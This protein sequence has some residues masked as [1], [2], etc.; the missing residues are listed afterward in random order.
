MLARNSRWMLVALAL[1]I[2]FAT[3]IAFKFLEAERAVEAEAAAQ[4]AAEQVQ[5]SAEA[6]L[7][8][9]AVAP[10]A[11]AVESGAQRV[12]V[13]GRTLTIHVVDP[14]GTPAV[15]AK[16]ALFRAEELLQ[17]AATDAQGSARFNA[18]EGMAEYALFAPGWALTRG[19]IDL[20]AGERTLTL[21]EGEVI[22]GS[23]LVDGAFPDPPIELDF[24]AADRSNGL[25]ALPKSVG[26]AL[27]AARGDVDG[28]IARTQANGA[29]E[30]RGLPPASAGTI[31][32]KGPY[33][34]EDEA[35][36]RR[37]NFVAVPAPRR[38]LLLRLTAGFELR[39]RVVDAAG[40]PVAGAPVTLYT[41]SS[42]P[43]VKNSGRM[44]QT[45]DSEGR[46]TISMSLTENTTISIDVDVA[47]VG[48]AGVR[49]YPAVLPA[50]PRGVID[51]GDLATDA[52]HQLSVRVRD[53]TEKAVEG[54]IVGPLPWHLQ[55]TGRTDAAGLIQLRL[56]ANDREI[57]A[58]AIGF[59]AAR[60]PVPTNASEL[61]VTLTKAT[62]LEFEIVPASEVKRELSVVLVGPATMFIG[63]DD[64]GPGTP[65]GGGRYSMDWGGDTTKC[66]VN[67]DKD[68]HWRIMGLVTNESMH[69]A[70]RGADGPDLWAGEIAPLT[71][72]EHRVVEMRLDAE[73]K[74]LRVRVLG[75][76]GK[77]QP[78]A[79]VFV[80][81]GHNGVQRHGLAVDE[82]GEVELQSLF[83]DRCTLEARA[84][85]FPA[86]MVVLHGVPAGTFDI[87]LDAPR[88][89][90]VDLVTPTGVLYE[91]KAR[92]RVQYGTMVVESSTPISPGRYRLDNLP[93]TEILIEAQ[94]P[95]GSATLLHDARTPMA[96]IVVGESGSIRAT[97]ER[98]AEEQVAVWS[99]AVAKPGAGDITRKELYFNEQGQSKPTLGSLALASY[100]VWLE[101]R[102]EDELNQWVRVGQP[103]KVVLDAQ[104][105]SAEIELRP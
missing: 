33:F 72:G 59:L 77:P 102:S 67:P 53:E 75:P 68:G 94:G 73:G 12:E 8:Q 43:D 34:I 57:A 2:V 46:Y 89:V 17:L 93:P 28:M 36:R 47:L 40:T 91:E 83:G 1:A 10:Q 88:S 32:W 16:L 85:E 26:V 11:A 27:R 48:G 99:L 35:G 45:A 9:P 90:E 62:M 63:Q 22:A 65:Q 100:D 13:A 44:S 24:D 14:S 37:G 69:A 104:H 95:N 64:D 19:E 5:P 101:R 82:L 15:D 103:T 81:D 18:G 3:A 29:F 6:K 31:R 86:K 56:G 79:S 55:P 97:I 105:T 78:H 41:S 39:L 54:A 70:L 60:V 23:V 84:P 98:T 20:A 21:V 51:L 92:V 71:A 76:D 30:F 52:A 80:G 50:K 66:A 58:T 4:R 96:R 42:G 7:E 87:V 74:S 25:G 61:T 49:K 38:D